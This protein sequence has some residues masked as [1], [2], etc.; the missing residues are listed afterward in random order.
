MK[1]FLYYISQTLAALL[2]IHLRF[3]Y[4][5]RLDVALL[6]F[7]VDNLNFVFSKIRKVPMSERVPITIIGAGAVGCAIAYQLSK[8]YQEI[9]VI[10][11]NSKVTAEN[12]SSRNSGVVHA[13]IYYPK[14]LGKLKAELCVR[15]NPELYDFC[16]EF[17][18]AHAQTGKL[19]LAAS[20]AE[21]E[22]LQ[23]SMRIARENQ[24]PGAQLISEQQA[25]KL[26][27]NIHCIKAGY[28]PTS[29][30]VEATQL[31]HK[32]Y[33]LASQ[34]GVFF[35]NGTEV[36]D[37]KPERGAFKITTRS[38]ER[39]EIFES[40]IVINSA[41]L[42]SDMVARWVNPDSPFDILPIRGESAKFYKNRRTELYHAG[43]NIYPTPHAI[44]TDGTKAE[45]SF[46]EFQKLFKQKKVVKTVGVHLTPTFD[47]IDNEYQ[48]GDIVTI[49][50]AA[51]RVENREDYSENLLPPVNYLKAVKNIFPALETEDI[52]LHQ[53]GVQA[54]LLQQYDWVIQPDE[55]FPRF[56]QLIGIDS[57]GL[58]A[59]L[60]IARYV[61]EL[62]RSVA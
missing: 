7:Q 25:K 3:I 20:E 53:T 57:P 48:I 1:I 39:K 40:E 46:S 5:F 45:V 8:S 13:G 55:K 26:E 62:I 52:S 54:K 34:A 44:Y 43:L 60:A 27:P 30:I 42:Y 29:G 17:E 58:T 2:L 56:I 21:L 19:V 47:L 36:V 15:G 28:F 14:D 11:K 41:G 22:Y 35:I 9:F 4:R 31:V 37:A 51:Q 33:S 49:G 18:V 12:Q 6:V 23:D 50:P 16:R 24:V 38:G 61:E 10:E 32:L 59:C